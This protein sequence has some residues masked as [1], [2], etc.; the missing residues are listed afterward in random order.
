MTNLIPASYL[1]AGSL[2]FEDDF[3]TIYWRLS[4]GGASYTGPTIGAMDND[5]NGDF[6]PPFAGPLPSTGL[7]ALRFQGASTARSTSNS[8]DYS[9]TPGAAVFTNNAGQNFTVTLPPVPGDLDGDRDVDLDDHALYAVCL[10]G[11]GVT[12]VP[13]QCALDEF[14]AG[15][16]DGDDDIDLRDTAAFFGRFIPPAP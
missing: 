7:Q 3:G 13:Q 12:V 5:L 2:T 8:T 9:L 15:D 11:P 14:A 16:R 4:W 6:G 1:P 10:S